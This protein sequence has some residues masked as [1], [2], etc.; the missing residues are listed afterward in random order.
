MLCFYVETVNKT[1]NCLQSVY[2]GLISLLCFRGKITAD[3]VWNNNGDM[4][5]NLQAGTALRTVCKVVF[6]MRV[7][8]LIF[9]ANEGRIFA[10]SLLKLVSSRW[11]M[12]SVLARGW[13]RLVLGLTRS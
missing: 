12:T 9:V 2:V 6:E 11:K 3:P 13:V 4:V 8:G 7:L 5:K 1:F 10:C